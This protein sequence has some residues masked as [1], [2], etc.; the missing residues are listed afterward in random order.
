MILTIQTIQGTR[1]VEDCQV[2][3]TVLRTFSDSI[4][5]IAAARTARTDEIPYTIR[6]KRVVI[7]RE[8]SLMGATTFD[9]AVFHPAQAAKSHSTF[10]DTTLMK[11]KWTGDSAFCPRR[12]LWQAIS[13][14]AAIVNSLDLW[15]NLFEILPDAAGTEADYIRDGSS[16]LAA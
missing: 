10:M 1:V 16:T 13:S 12:V 2:V 4:P 9:D 8:V 15:P 14:A 6:R 3:V 7:E 5:G 11:A